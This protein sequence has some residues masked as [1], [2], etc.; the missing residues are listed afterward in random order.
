MSPL[1]SGAILATL[2]CYA[3][4]MALAV[5]RLLRARG[6]TLWLLENGTGGLISDWL[7]VADP[8]GEVFRGG[9]IDRRMPAD[10]EAVSERIRD[11]LASGAADH[12]L[13]VGPFPEPPGRVLIGLAA[14]GGPQT[15][16]VLFAGH[17]DILRERCAKQA[18][19]RLR[20]ALLAGTPS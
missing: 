14:G 12:V 16:R 17:P 8:T 9:D 6:E 1:L 7:A 2:A 19:D 5:V 18:L 15:S 11:V 13:A 4:A 3:I 10:A 20:H